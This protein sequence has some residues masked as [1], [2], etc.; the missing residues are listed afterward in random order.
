MKSL[1]VLATAAAL[2]VGAVA[3][4]KKDEPKP[5]ETN[6]TSAPLEQRPV[7]TTGGTLTTGG[8]SDPGNTQGGG[9]SIG[10]TEGSLG[11]GAGGSGNTMNGSGSTMSKGRDAGVIGSDWPAVPS[12]RGGS[13]SLQAPSSEQ[14]QERSHGQVNKTTT[15]GDGTSGQYTG[16]KGTYGGKATHGTGVVKD[17]NGNPKDTSTNKR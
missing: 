6:T 13:S 4:E 1:S 2:L 10:T 8:A 11:A 15:L 14:G 5:S 16:G 17:E 3:C 9:A 7:E 12:E